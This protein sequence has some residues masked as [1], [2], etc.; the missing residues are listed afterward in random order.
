MKVLGI[1][2]ATNAGGA[3]LVENGKLIAEDFSRSET[4][5]SSRL[6]P[7]IDR[8]L[9]QAGWQ[10]RDIGLVAVSIGP[11]SFTGLRIGLAT[12]KGIAVASG[13]QIIGV[14]T[15]DAFA[16][17][18]AKGSFDAPIRP[19]LDA[20]KAEVF[21]AGFDRNGNR[22]SPDENITP[23][24]LLDK[25]LKSL[26]YPTE[27]QVEKTADEKVLL[28]GDGYRRY[29]QIFVKALGK[30]AVRPSPELDDPHPGAVAELGLIM[31][32]NGIRNNI[33]NLAPIYVRGAD[34]VIRQSAPIKGTR[35]T[36]KTLKRP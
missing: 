22:L 5:H 30:N 10:A 36:P 31:Y 16:F 21:T 19:I 6:L 27:C 13:A 9:K 32:R 12:A 24:L 15:L 4:T 11:G 7:S 28:A 1:E 34:A 20:R 26:V 14:P 25:G 17:L 2:T 3:A 35:L 29:E 8:L 33:E 18:L 23:E